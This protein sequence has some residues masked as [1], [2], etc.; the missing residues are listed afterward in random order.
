MDNSWGHF[1]D[2]HII[3]GFLSPKD[4]LEPI[5]VPKDSYFVMGDNR[6]RSLDSR[7]WGFVRKDDLVGKALI[8]YFSWNGK[9]DEILH[10]V[11]WS[12]IARLIR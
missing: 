11:R 3:P 12:R 5:K 4:N 8:I 7:F 10:Y 9:S 2:N 6:D 1:S